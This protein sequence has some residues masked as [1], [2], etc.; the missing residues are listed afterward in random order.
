MDNNTIKENFDN[1]INSL[2]TLIEKQRQIAHNAIDMDDWEKAQTILIEA[3]KNIS[4]LST[5]RNKVITI[6]DESLS[7]DLISNYQL[8]PELDNNIKEENNTAPVP[9]TENTATTSSNINI[10]EQMVVPDFYEILNDIEEKHISFNLYGNTY[11]EINLV[12]SLM[13]IST[14]FYDINQ[15]AF[16]MVI[17][18]PTLLND[19]MIYISSKQI[20]SRYRKLFD[21][22]LFL[23]DK[24]SDDTVLEIISLLI[25]IYGVNWSD[26]NLR[27]DGRQIN[28]VYDD[29]TNNEGSEI[30]TEDK[31]HNPDKTDLVDELEQLI[32]KYPFSMSIISVDET[33]GK[34]FTFSEQQGKTE[35]V[36]PHRLSNGLWVD[37]DQ[38]D[39]QTFII[40]VREFCAS[41]E[42]I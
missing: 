21:K 8:C 27:V 40:K 20:N 42:N 30:T 41:S 33:F 12:N 1:I 16:G 2:S 36:D 38:K 15:Q 18:S 6:R 11:N 39:L 37:K 9:V 29:A 26:L 25:K 23:F 5:I 32:I 10:N 7:I 24:I 35:M 4:A 14:I 22:D 28:I 34:E 17:D 3:N 13:R 31:Y 19:G